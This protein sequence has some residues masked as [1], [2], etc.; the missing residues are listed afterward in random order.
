MRRQR[1]NTRAGWECSGT[2][3]NFTDPGIAVATGV[4]WRAGR[5]QRRIEGLRALSFEEQQLGAL[6]DAGGQ[7]TRAHQAGLEHL[8]L[9]TPHLDPTWRDEP[10]LAHQ[11]H[12]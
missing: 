11:A 5:I 8:R 9:A 6:T 7:G 1:E 2:F 4:G 12:G 3:A 10:Q